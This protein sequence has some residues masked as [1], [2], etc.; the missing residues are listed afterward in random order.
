MILGTSLTYYRC[1]P[2]FIRP[3]YLADYMR[4]HSF[5]IQYEAGMRQSTRNQVPIT[6]QREFFHVIPPSSEQDSIAS[7]LDQLSVAAGRLQYLYEQK[8]VALDMLKQSLLNEAF[9]G[10]L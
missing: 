5:R 10:N 7:E 6:K 1:N 2:S 3:A 9:S 8:L 4:S